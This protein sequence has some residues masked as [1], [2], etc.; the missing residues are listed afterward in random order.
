MIFFYAK[1]N[2]NLMKGG[3]GVRVQGL[4]FK[5]EGT[6]VPLKLKNVL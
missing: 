2:R 1:R 5:V 6:A 3:E 4:R